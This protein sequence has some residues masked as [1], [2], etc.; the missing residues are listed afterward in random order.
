MCD[1]AAGFLKE[2]CLRDEM[3]LAGLLIPMSGVIHRRQRK[4]LDD[5]YLLK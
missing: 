2:S 5:G 4:L 1:I 3:R